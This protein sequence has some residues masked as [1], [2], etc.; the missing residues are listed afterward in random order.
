M[1]I[2]FQFYVSMNFIGKHLKVIFLSLNL[3]G[4]FYPKNISLYI[5]VNFSRLSG[6][7]SGTFVS[8]ALKIFPWTTISCEKENPYGIS[9]TPYII[10]TGAKSILRHLWMLCIPGTC[11]YRKKTVYCLLIDSI[12]R[13]LFILAQSTTEVAHSPYKLFAYELYLYN[14][15]LFM[16]NFS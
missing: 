6:M 3:G 13:T 1:S 8:K 14:K 7:L 12:P 11:C 10:W 16:Y 4:F 5:V 15:I 9:V 2:P